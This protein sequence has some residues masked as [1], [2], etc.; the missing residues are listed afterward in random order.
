ML[1]QQ[2]DS[3]NKTEMVP[4]IGAV[5]SFRPGDRN[6]TWW[7]FNARL[8]QRWS[9]KLGICGCQIWAVK[10]NLD[11]HSWQTST[12]MNDYLGWNWISN[13]GMEYKFKLS[14]WGECISIRQVTKTK[15]KK[16][17]IGNNSKQSYQDEATVPAWGERIR[18][19][20]A[21]QD[22]TSV[23]GWSKYIRMRQ[24]YQVED[25]ASYQNKVDIENKY[26]KGT[27]MHPNWQDLFYLYICLIY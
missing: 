5:M 10:S 19:R 18:M 25:E 24:A 23:S 27:T 11:R 8:G 20:Q 22:Q 6:P 17:V 9:C 26:R 16:G 21:Y 1:K 4:L 12:K 15:W 13:L 7:Q 3:F 14:G 2:R